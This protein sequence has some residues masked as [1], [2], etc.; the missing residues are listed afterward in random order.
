MCQNEGFNKEHKLGV[1]ENNVT[2]DWF[3]EDLF[4]FPTVTMA[5]TE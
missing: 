5:A 2:H 3:V 1:I 4:F